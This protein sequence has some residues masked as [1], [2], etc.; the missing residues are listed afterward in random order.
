MYFTDHPIFSNACTMSTTTAE[1]AKAWD[2]HVRQM[3]TEK[4][5]QLVLQRIYFYH[6]PTRAN[7]TGAPGRSASVDYDLGRKMLANLDL[8][9]F[10][11]DT[12]QDAR[13]FGRRPLT[14]LTL[15]LMDEHQLPAK[16]NLDVRKMRRF[17]SCI[18][19]SYRQL[20]YHNVL[21][22]VDVLRRLHTI[23]RSLSLEPLQ[24]LGMY[25]AA[26]MHDYGHGGVTNSF[27]VATGNQL[28]RRYNDKSPWENFHAAESLE[29]LESDH[30]AFMPEEI[31]RPLREMVIELI[32]ATDMSRHVEML[33]PPGTN[34]SKMLWLLRLAIKCADV[35]H[36]AAP[37]DVHK[38]WS[39]ALEQEL[40]MQAQLERQ[41]GLPETWLQM[42]SSQ[43]RFF[44]VIIVPMFRLL[45]EEIP[46]T[47]PLL[48]QAKANRS[49]YQ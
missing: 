5:Q 25:L 47:L 34:Q 11:F 23:I 4:E 14:T 8:T 46:A 9:A 29:L 10:H 18:E 48:E 22:V 17:M 20:P 36:T 49:I 37:T 1:H 12:F 7:S 6:I 16:L 27:L 15:H 26:A 42:R 24:M 45:A 19:D 28:A 2:E 3:D 33:R 35:G 30:L 40:Q 44:D 21:H 31:F 39:A 32:L 13:Q 43:Q 38:K 41:R